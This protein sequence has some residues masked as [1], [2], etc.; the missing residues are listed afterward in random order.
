MLRISLLGKGGNSR[1]LRWTHI[2]IITFNIVLTMRNH[3]PSHSILRLWLDRVGLKN[4]LVQA[5]RHLVV[6]IMRQQ[7]QLHHRR[8]SL[9]CRQP[10]IGPT[11]PNPPRQAKQSHHWQTLLCRLVH[12]PRT[13][14][15]VRSVHQIPN[16]HIG[17][18]GRIQ[19]VM[20]V[21]SVK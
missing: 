6:S 9:L 10:S 17:S 21:E 18:G 7:V 3:Q 16:G 19:A 15:Q 4:E 1:M 5:W 14:H 11:I 2:T 20:H 8:G 13:F 12:Q